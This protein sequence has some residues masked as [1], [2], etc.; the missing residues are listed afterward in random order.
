MKQ[1]FR[2]IMGT[3]ALSALWTGC[4]NIIAPGGGP[5]DEK[6]PELRYRTLQDSALNFRGGKI[7]FEFNEFVRLQDVQNQLIISPFLKQT[8]KL[9]VHKRRV[10]MHLPD[11]LLRSNT[12]YQIS[13]GKA[14]QDIHEGNALPNLSFTFSTGSYFDSLSVVGR[15]ID[16]STGL[17]DTAMTAVL[18]PSGLS[19]SALMKE[20]PLYAQKA[21]EG[22]FRIEH[23][24]AGSFTLYGLCD[25]N[26]NF[27]YD[28]PPEKIAFLS[29]NVQ[30]GDTTVH[31]LYSFTEAG[32][33]DS[34]RQAP[35]RM[36]ARQGTK[37][38]EPLSF[39]VSADTA[40]RERRSVELGEALKIRFNTPIREP[41][42]GKV[43]LF[44]GQVFD[45]QAQCTRDTDH[46]VLLV[47][48][49]WQGD[50]LY[51]LQLLRGYAQ[52]SSGRSAPAATFQFRT[53]RASDYGTLRIRT[54][55]DPKAILQVMK[56]EQMLRQVA[57]TNSLVQMSL[58]PPGNYALRILH[59]ENGNGRWDT[60]R[61][62]GKRLEPERMEQLPGEVNIRANWEVVLDLRKP[63]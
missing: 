36:S 10:Y 57:L 45:A 15:C 47:N 12:T 26:G 19:D 33:T 62:Y 60:G 21:R 59:D 32:P 8:P 43:R 5:R 13:L 56:G 51:T 23:L 39:T 50:A 7:T 20:K 4:A 54:T 34:A 55:T 25:K 41:D 1:A 22:N 17:P 3:F 14:V 48:T 42:A 24:P 53:K 58:L 44:Q 18:Y 9:T 6:A 29:G 27:R 52:D 11:S 35:K 49:D 16:A 40:N 31:S 37:I 30:A 46:T 38:A 61:L 28:G 2:F 63:R